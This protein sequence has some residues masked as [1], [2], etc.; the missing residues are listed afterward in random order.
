MG[1][2]SP[3]SGEI[4]IDGKK[5]EKIE[6][7]SWQENI[8][9]VPQNINLIDD[10]VAENIAFSDKNYEINMK[11][12]IQIT[13]IVSIHDFIKNELPDG[14]LTKLGERGV[15][16]S[17]GQK[18]RIGIARALYKNPSLLVLDEA[19]SAL[20]NI[21]QE[22]II[23]LINSKNKDLTVVTVAHR[24]SSLKGCD[25]IFLILPNGSISSGTYTELMTT[26]KYF[27]EMV[28]AGNDKAEGLL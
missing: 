23:K 2:Y 4:L 20:D 24:L 9:Y 27:N 14:Y 7:K 25:K 1:L 8:G 21:S 22:T 26:N 11:K 5:L 12:I 13:K 3:T 6:I 10:T 16:L 18:Q 17:G 19:T 15:R 28:M